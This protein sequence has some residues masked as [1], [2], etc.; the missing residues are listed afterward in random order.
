M[1]FSK[2]R[3]KEE[4]EQRAEHRVFSTDF[5]VYFK[6]GNLI[7]RAGAGFGKDLSVHGIC[8]RTPVKFGKEEKIEL[9]IELPL[10]FPNLKNILTKARV[11]RVSP[12]EKNRWEVACELYHVKSAYAEAIRQ[13]L[14]WIEFSTSRAA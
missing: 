8:F 10:E 9:V 14:W 13:F 5:L 12:I 11:V 6:K 3:N 1:Y 7:K 2:N 4:K